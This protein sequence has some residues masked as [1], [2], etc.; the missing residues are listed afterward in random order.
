MTTQ[1]IQDYVDGV[2][3][4]NFQGYQVEAGEMVTSPGGDGRFL[5]KVVAVRYSGLPVGRDVFLAIGETDKKC[6]IIKF[7]D[8][9]C[10]K[11]G[12]IDLDLVL[13]KE[14]GIGEKD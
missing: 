3:R 4:S 6:Q 1:E 7:G 8:S 5:G 13:A 14:L 9:E 10:L 11:P 12:E 2:I